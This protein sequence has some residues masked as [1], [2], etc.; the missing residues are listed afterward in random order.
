MT[1]AED[2]IDPQLAF[3][4]A[5]VWREARISCPHPDLLQSFAQGGLSGGAAE[6]VAFHL[7]DSRCPW[8]NAVLEDLRARDDAARAPVLADL[9]DRLLRSTAAA[10]RRTRA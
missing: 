8:C 2:P 6:F 1:G 10:L 4:V 3:T 7:Q 9:R 5:A